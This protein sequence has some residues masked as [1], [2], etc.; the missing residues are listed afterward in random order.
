M[1]TK[2]TL[3][4]F[5]IFLFASCG[6]SNQPPLFEIEGTYTKGGHDDSYSVKIEKDENGKYTAFY[7]YIEGMLPPEDMFDKVVKYEEMP[8]FKLDPKTMEFTSDN[9]NG[10]FEQN[11]FMQIIFTDKKDIFDENLVLEK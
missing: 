7:A 10:K 1:K 2:F 5:A 3:I 9:G 6:T 11:E 4:A 8:N